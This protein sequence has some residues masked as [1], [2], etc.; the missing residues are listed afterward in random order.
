ML[1]WPRYG[2]QMAGRM[3]N[4]RT[5]DH[6]QSPNH[7]HRPAADEVVIDAEREPYEGSPN[8]SQKERNPWGT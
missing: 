4:V 5:S 1:V 2:R 6:W 8:R 7:N 3:P